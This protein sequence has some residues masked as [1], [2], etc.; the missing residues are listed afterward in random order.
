MSN[1]LLKDKTPLSHFCHQT[2][3]RT[4]DPQDRY[5]L[6]QNVKGQYHVQRSPSIIP[7]TTPTNPIQSHF[8]NRFVYYIP[9]YVEQHS[10]YGNLAMGWRTGVQVS[11]GAKE[12]LSETSRLAPEHKS[13][14]SHVV[15]RFRISRAIPPHLPPYAPLV[16]PG[17]TLPLPPIYIHVSQEAPSLQL[18]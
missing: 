9:I 6:L 8:V 18:F 14:H 5:T 17:T 3:D 15:L 12:L 7:I 4:Q 2:R 1:L 10:Y 16:C 11:A 13:D